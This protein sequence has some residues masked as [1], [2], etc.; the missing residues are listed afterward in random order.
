[1]GGIFSSHD[2]STTAP[3]ISSIQLQTSSYGR[4]ITWIFGRQR[5][6]P[7][8]IQYDD[9]KPVPHTTT[10]QVGKGGG[11]TS[12]NTDYT[13][14][15]AAIMALGSGALESVGKVWKDKEKTTLADLHFDFYNGDQHQEPYPYF[16]S[17]HPERALGYRGIA[18]VA[19]GAYN[20]GSNASFGNHTFEVQARGSIAANHPGALI[21]DAEVVDV[22]SALLTDTEQGVGLD[23]ATLGDLAA[24]R[25][26]C[27]AN[28]LWV[29]PAY[30][31]QRG[32]FEYIKNLLTIG[33][34]DCVYS[35]GRFKIVP[36][37][38]VP[39]SSALATYVPTIGPVYD[40]GEDDFIGDAGT[41]AIKIMQKSA[42]ES[43]NHVRVRFSDRA[44]DYNDN[45]AE[46]SDDADIEQYGLRSKDVI[47]LKEIADAAVAQKVA[48]F[49]LHRSLYILNRYEFRLPWKYVRLEPMD[50]VTLTYPRKYLDRTPVLVIEVNEDD[51]GLLTVIAE[52]YPLGS[53]RAS[54]QP[55]PGIDNTAPNYAIT[56]GDATPP[57][58][59]EAPG[60]LTKNDAQ[61]W[62]ATSGGPNWGGCVV[63]ASTDDRSY[64]R[65]GT[66][67][68]AARHGTL[69]APLAK[70][71]AIDQI[72]ALGVDLGVSG[73]DLT[74]CSQDNARDLLTACYVGGEY[75]A[76][77][78]EALTGPHAYRLSYLVRGAYGSTVTDHAQGAPFAMLDAGIFKYAYP[79]EWVGKTVWIKL[80]SFNKFGNG[81]QDLSAVAAYRH[82]IVGAQVDQVQFLVAHPRVFSIQLD[83]G[84]PALSA[85]QVAF[86]EIWYGTTPDRI[87]ASLLGAFASPQSSHAITGLAAGASFYFWV[88]LIDRMGNVGA[89]YPTGAGVPGASST[90]ATVILDWVAG[91]IGKTQLAADLLAPIERIGGLEAMQDSLAATHLTSL[92]ASNNALI[93]EG[94]KRTQALLAEATARGAAI[95]LVQMSVQTAT[96]SLASRMDTVSAANAATAAAVQNESSARTTETSALARSIASI[97]AGANNAAAA[98]VAEQTARVNAD[99]ALA[100]R[101]DT[102]Q[103]SA[104]NAAAAVT[105]EQTARA[106]A[107]G[108]LGTRIDAVQA[109]ANGAAA[110]VVSE[111]TARANADG[112]L[113]SRIETA[114]A[115]ANNASAAVQSTSAALAGT[116]GKLSALHTIKTQVTSGGRTYWAG[117]GVGVEVD[118]PAVESQILLSAQRLAVI[119]ENSGGLT[120][121]FVVQDGQVFINQ[122]FIGAGW[123]KNLHV[124]KLAIGTDNIDFD[125]ITSGAT[126]AGSASCAIT[127]TPHGGKVV[128]FASG[129]GTDG[130]GAAGGRSTFGVVMKKNGVEIA[131]NTVNIFG[132]ESAYMT[133]FS[134]DIPTAGVAVVYSAEAYGSR[135]VSNQNCRIFVQE[136]KR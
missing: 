21:P 98:V 45:I 43:F 74:G 80:A 82:A 44:N 11:A 68:S 31:E 19:S 132:G 38:D 51:D 25:S 114:Q 29:S 111:Q 65:I 10:Q 78:N 130:S 119:N 131:R 73:G 107:D 104:N 72:N 103:A 35:G 22:V 39:A 105:S 46:S 69:S 50:V 112:A 28:G 134:N 3:V 136:V 53:N 9:F 55:V 91:Q 99:G 79:R 94:N 85:E 34:A 42:E 8:L 135:G 16:V 89:F 2:V 41:D 64:Q 30:T 54:A 115:S 13:Y 47:D 77:A 20:L 81:L 124:D 66:V 110:A 76:Y 127:I 122:A 88:R 17:K 1:M 100:T 118:G 120:T 84:V 61:L 92:M 5:I 113:S 90:D 26:Y 126:A 86:T 14:T 106:N 109:S 33:F 116:N 96:D 36:Y 62:M 40:L 63:W 7:N 71:E 48:D 12:S 24:F 60:R 117:I 56:P 83:W 49:I 18:Y 59:F 4:P 52:D 37:S 6:A 102:A 87:N 121:P 23:P 125:A 128:V 108:A 57:L 95:S 75:L 32:A 133:C 67:R 93:A 129:G 15:V 97:V 58:L 101:I 70:G 123:I 27:L